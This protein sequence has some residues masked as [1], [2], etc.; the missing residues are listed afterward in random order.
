[1]AFQTHGISCPS[2]KSQPDLLS[3]FHIWTHSDLSHLMTLFL[4]Q[5]CISL[6]QPVSNAQIQN[7]CVH[8]G[9]SIV[10]HR[11]VQVDESCHK[12]MDH[13]SLS[14]LLWML[15]SMQLNWFDWTLWSHALQLPFPAISFLLLKCWCLLANY[16]ILHHISQSYRCEDWNKSWRS[17][18][19][20]VSSCG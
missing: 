16:Y 14:F 11:A 1:M 18:S 10:R 20:P 5:W 15:C 3:F 13:N 2:S 4:T 19:S 12:D 7:I 9:W 17:E 8:S 6:Y